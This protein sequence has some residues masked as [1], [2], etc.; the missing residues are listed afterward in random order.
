MSVGKCVFLCFCSGVSG[1]L[2]VRWLEV[3]ARVG[4]RG[5]RATRGGRRI[6][7]ARVLCLMNVVF[8]DNSV[9]CM[10]IKVGDVFWEYCGCVVNV[11][12][13]DV[14]TLRWSV[15]EVIG[16]AYLIVAVGVSVE[17]LVLVLEKEVVL[18]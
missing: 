15:D 3:W 10:Y 13:S 12:L 18:V 11:K 7:D 5:E 9:L 4:R 1:D 6:D 16:R 8:D 2:W 17:L 14:F